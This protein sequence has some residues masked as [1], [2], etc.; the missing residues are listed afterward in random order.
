MKKLALLTISAALLTSA[1]QAATNQTIPD[2]G[3][4]NVNGAKVFFKAEG[5]GEPL[6]MIHGYPLNG[7]LFKKNRNLAGY[8]VVTV[9][10]PGFGKSTLA[11]GQPVSIENYASTMLGF[12]DALGLQKT[13]AAG[14]R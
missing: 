7:E 11:P 1:A 8:R 4:V 5:Q 14:M 2:R 12:M 6:L 9:D 3:T 10:L 13:T